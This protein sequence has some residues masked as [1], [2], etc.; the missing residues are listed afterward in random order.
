MK[1]SIVTARAAVL[2]AL[3]TTGPLGVG[4]ADPVVDTGTATN[5]AKSGGTAGSTSPSSKAA[6]A[7][8]NVTVCANTSSAPC[9]ASNVAPGAVWQDV[10]TTAIKTSN[11]A[12]LFVGA[13]LVTGL[14]TSTTVTGNGS[15][16]TS[17]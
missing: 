2:I 4:C 9:V 3:C 17:K 5:S 13:S 15:G 10:M 11:V 14:F 12:D 6:A 7:I 16:S 8:N 1:I